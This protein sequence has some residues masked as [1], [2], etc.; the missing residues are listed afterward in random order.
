MASRTHHHYSDRPDASPRR[1]PVEFVHLIL[2]AVVCIGVFHVLGGRLDRTQFAAP[3]AIAFISACTGLLLLS[4]RERQLENGAARMAVEYELVCCSEMRFSSLISNSPDITIV[5]APYGEVT[6][7]SAGVERILGVDAGS[8]IGNPVFDCVHPDEAAL[9]RLVIQRVSENADASATSEARL[10]KANGDWLDFEIVIANMLGTPSIEGILLTC[11]DISERKTIERQLQHQAFNDSLTGLYNCAVFTTRLDHTIKR[12]KANDTTLSVISIDVRRL[13]QVNETFGP[14]IGDR[15]LIESAQRLLGCVNPTDTV[16]RLGGDEFGI[17]VDNPASEIIA[18]RVAEKAA[19]ALSEPLNF[20][21]TQFLPAV[22]I[23]MVVNGESYATPCDLIRDAQTAMYHAKARESA[24]PVIF[25]TGMTA[26]PSTH[27]RIETEL[28]LALVQG[29]FEVHY[30]PIAGLNDG[31][32]KQVEALVRWKHPERGLLPPSEFVAIA[33]ASGLFSGIGLWVLQRAC[34]DAATW[35]REVP[36]APPFGV[37]V[38]MSAVQLSQEHLDFQ[39]ESVLKQ[40]GLA[41]AFLTLEISDAALMQ[42][43]DSLPDKLQSLKNMGVRIAVDNF[44][45]GD[46]SIAYLRTL[47]IDML[48]LDKALV[49]RLGVKD[50]NDTVAAVIGLGKTMALDIA[51]EGIETAVQLAILKDLGCEKGQGYFIA[52][53]MPVEHILSI[54]KLQLPLNAYDEYRSPSASAFAA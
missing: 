16:S 28:R 12:A 33:E 27:P 50:A 21:D 19:R 47:P 41:P 52:R 31:A 2:T 53:P 54:L 8:L 10:L 18:I 34:E 23:G 25:T 30:Q 7:A 42:C 5:L 13:K 20:G 51:C 4:H 46:S 38:N 22:D 6:F 44:G 11:R 1:Y 15:L 14:E 49:H 32:M 40:S 39:I 29:Q 48:K 35:Q 24:H 26:S 17:L 37:A 9:L 45:A 3:A 36:Q 43:D